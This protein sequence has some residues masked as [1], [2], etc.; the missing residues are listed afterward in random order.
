MIV[1]K[2]NKSYDTSDGSEQQSG[3]PL[4]RVQSKGLAARDRWEDDGG[5][6]GDQPPFVAGEKP[7][8]SVL[9][10]SDLN[11]AIRRERLED[12]GARLQQESER[13]ERARLR[14]MQ[15]HADQAAAAAR[16]IRD[17]YR[18]AWEHA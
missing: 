16:A 1:S 4:R 7:P 18:N 12:D 2:Y 3:K 14:E 5:P 15:L 10:L 6:V 9:S 17:R 8:W 11:E 13:T